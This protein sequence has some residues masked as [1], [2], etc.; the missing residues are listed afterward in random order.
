LPSI[1][2]QFAFSVLS[3]KQPHTILTTITYLFSSHMQSVTVAG[4][5]STAGAKHSWNLKCK[6]FIWI[7]VV[8]LEGKAD[9][10]ARAKRKVKTGIA[11]CNAAA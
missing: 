10:N 7:G 1:L 11:G 9:P 2:C 8:A 6:S 5:W 4:K 3:N